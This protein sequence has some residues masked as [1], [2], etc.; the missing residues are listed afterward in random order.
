MANN[1][2]SNYTE[3]TATPV[4]ADE[5]M[6]RD[7]TDGKNKKLLFGTFWKWVAK[8]LNE[9]TISE[10]QT[11]NKTII[12]A[13]NALNSDRVISTKIDTYNGEA[14]LI[15]PYTEGV[16]FLIASV[17][18]APSNTEQVLYILGYHH[19]YENCKIEK[20]YGSYDAISEVIFDKSSGML[21]FK[22][23]FQSMLCRIMLFKNE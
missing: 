11:N 19:G 12:G 18:D 9:A 7:S 23:A 10:L 22:F 4:D 2:W 15:P 14:A 13:I 1:I 6:V 5:V 16:C 8:K 20:I 3:K 17:Y 21:K